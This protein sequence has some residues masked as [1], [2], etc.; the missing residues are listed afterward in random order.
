MAQD[1]KICDLILTAEID[2]QDRDSGAVWNTYVQIWALELWQSYLKMVPRMLDTNFVLRGSSNQ[3]ILWY[4]KND[5]KNV[6]YSWKREKNITPNSL[7]KNVLNIN[8]H[9]KVWH[10]SHLSESDSQQERLKCESRISDVT[11]DG[12]TDNS[13]VK[14]SDYI[15]RCVFAKTWC[16]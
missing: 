11:L 10:Q 16:K 4:H 12:D 2:D 6:L 13:N 8:N 5:E 14:W 9:I 1:T 7:P 15:T 3:S